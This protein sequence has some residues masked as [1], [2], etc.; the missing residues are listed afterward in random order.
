M[1]PDRDVGPLPL[2]GFGRGG[3]GTLPAG[4]PAVRW[5]HGQRWGHTA[6]RGDTATLG[7]SPAS[8][9]LGPS[10]PPRPEA[11]AFEPPLLRALSLAWEVSEKFFLQRLQLFTWAG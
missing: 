4:S 10:V 3:E 9:C 5:Y 6:T 8:K 11:G 2:R 7:H 1:L